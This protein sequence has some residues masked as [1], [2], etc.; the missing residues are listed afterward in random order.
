MQNEIPYLIYA[1]PSS[2]S[3]DIIIKELEIIK[4]SDIKIITHKNEENAMYNS[5]EWI[6]PTAFG[7][8]IL[9]PYFEVFLS[10]AGKDHYAILKKFIN[11]FL[12]KGKEY[13]F[14]IIAASKSTEKLSKKYNKSFS[15]SLEIQTKN[16]RF[17][18]VLFENSLNLDDWKKSSNKI[19]DLFQEH[20]ENYPS[21]K[22]T[23]ML[24]NFEDKPYRKLYITVDKFPQK[25]TLKDDTGMTLEYKNFK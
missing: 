23:S 15:V 18:K 19:L 16:N 9:K 7:V 5:F 11:N 10:E 22:L 25:Y 8:H 1:F 20:Y 2:F 17:V 12:Q 14:T 4:N 6:I 13:N 24:K 21:D 3:E